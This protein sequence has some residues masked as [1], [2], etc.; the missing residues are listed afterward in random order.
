MAPDVSYNSAIARELKEGC[1]LLTSVIK[2][3]KVQVGCHKGGEDWDG[4]CS[5]DEGITREQW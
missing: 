3:G 2:K 5:H 4:V 1:F